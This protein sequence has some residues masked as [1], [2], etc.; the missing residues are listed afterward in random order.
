[1]NIQNLIDLRKYLT[2]LEHE[3]GKISLKFSVQ[4]LLDPKVLEIINENKNTP[5]PKAIYNTSIQKIKR[6]I[7]IE[8]DDS[9]IIPNELEEILTTRQRDQFNQLIEKYLTILT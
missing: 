3:K 2:V 5:K 6:I 1:M 9:V 7:T 4:A 8:Y